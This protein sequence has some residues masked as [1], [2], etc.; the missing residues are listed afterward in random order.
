MPA[1]VNGNSVQDIVAIQPAAIHPLF[2]PRRVIRK[3]GQHLY[4]IAAR[5]QKHAERS[6]VRGEPGELRRVVDAPD[7]DA[8]PS[9]LALLLQLEGLGRGEELVDAVEPRG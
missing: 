8:H 9:G 3:R 7:D 1:A 6:V 5:A 4:S 2:S